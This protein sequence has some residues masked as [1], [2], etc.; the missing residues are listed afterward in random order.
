MKFRLTESFNVWNIE[1]ITGYKPMT[2]YFEDFSIA[3][4]YGVDAIKD[5]FNKNFEQAKTNYKWLTEF[6]MA[7]N[8]KTWEHHG[9]NEQYAKLYNSLWEQAD[10]YAM[11][12]LKDEEIQYFLRTTD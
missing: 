10:A 11:D 3:D 1:E 4:Q 6:V 2:T 9:H 8:W 7:C 5:T 12:N